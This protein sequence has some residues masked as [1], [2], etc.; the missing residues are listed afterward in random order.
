MAAHI[1]GTGSRTHVVAMNSGAVPEF[2][3]G[4]A[5]ARFVQAGRSMIVSSVN[6]AGQASL[7]RG[8]G[9]RVSADQRLM[10][11]FISR[12]QS[13]AVLTA[14]LET[15]VIA[16]VFA[17]PIS[18]RALQIKG[19]NGS[20]RAIDDSEWAAV[21]EYQNQMVVEIGKVGFAEPVVRAML[22]CARDDVVAVS[23]VP[24]SAFDQTPG[25]RA[26]EAIGPTA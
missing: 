10:T 23:F 9:A 7:M 19:I 1:G 4:D 18:N 20:V 24:T 5:I 11:L 15:G 12:R 14:V 2:V 21:A 22:A 25:A 13:E 3:L 6:R 17:E 8:L 16:V 26:G